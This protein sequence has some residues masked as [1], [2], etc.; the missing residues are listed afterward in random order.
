MLLFCDISICN[1]LFFYFS[2]FKTTL[3]EERVAGPPAPPPL[4]IIDTQQVDPPLESPKIL[5]S[6][7]VDVT[8]YDGFEI[9]EEEEEDLNGKNHQVSR[10]HSVPAMLAPTKLPPRRKN[11]EPPPVKI[12]QIEKEEYESDDT[13]KEENEPMEKPVSAPRKQSILTRQSG[14][15]HDSEE[16]SK[17]NSLDGPTFDMRTE[18]G[19]TLVVLGNFEDEEQDSRE[20]VLHSSCDLENEYGDNEMELSSAKL[21]QSHGSPSS[22]HSEPDDAD[23]CSVSVAVSVSSIGSDDEESQ[24]ETGEDIVNQGKLNGENTKQLKIKRKNERRFVNDEKVS[25]QLQGNVT[26]GDQRISKE[27]K[28]R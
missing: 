12:A 7:N 16:H 2:I 8:D 25:H 4:E 21:N 13:A 5:P 6:D 23:P 18:G 3:A 26:I 1:V 14:L 24:Q 28:V 27:K 20:N 17:P 9:E 19:E 10:R 11:S 15:S 22:V